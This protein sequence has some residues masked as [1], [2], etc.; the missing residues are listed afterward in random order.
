MPSSATGR[1]DGRAGMT[2]AA[3]KGLLSLAV[4]S[5]AWAAVVSVIRREKKK[6]A[7][8]GHTSCFTFCVSFAT[9]V[10][11]REAEKSQSHHH[12]DGHHFSLGVLERDLGYGHQA[13][14]IT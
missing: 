4:V 9:P 5:F 11:S 8:K 7:L 10:L 12:W 3:S 1:V 13:C 14:I 2:G 6:K